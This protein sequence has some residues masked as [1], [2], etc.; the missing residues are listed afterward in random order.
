MTSCLPMMFEGG[1]LCRH[2]SCN[3][4]RLAIPFF[5][6]CADKKGVGAIP[7]A[8]VTR[9]PGDPGIF[10]SGTPQIRRMAESTLSPV[11]LTG[12]KTPF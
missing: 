10:V 1:S 12:N 9:F 2:L 4:F 3:S 8:T 11:F 5:W 6:Q 7:M